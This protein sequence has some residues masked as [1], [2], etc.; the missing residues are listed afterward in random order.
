MALQRPK[1]SPFLPIFKYFQLGPQLTDFCILCGIF[2]D[3]PCS[4]YKNI[5][6]LPNTKAFF[7]HTV[8]A[9]TLS[10]KNDHIQTA[11]E[12]LLSYV[13]IFRQWRI[14]GSQKDLKLY[15]L[16][17]FLLFTTF[18]S[19]DVWKMSFLQKSR[20][21]AFSKWSY[22]G[23]ATLNCT[24][25]WEDIVFYMFYKLP[26]EIFLGRAFKLL[27]W[28]SENRQFC[29][30]RKLIYLTLLTFLHEFGSIWAFRTLRIIKIEGKSFNLS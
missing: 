16:N 30:P 7:W 2:L 10:T 8:K 21:L 15:S 3:L 17:F 18:W 27:I 26:V 24:K 14:D 6:M 4:F 1:N 28:T 13:D 5:L 19:T 23:L 25:I 20:F 12:L 22:S 29:S 9:G 11:I